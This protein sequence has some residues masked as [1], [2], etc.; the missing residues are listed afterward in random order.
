MKKDIKI[1]LSLGAIVIIIIF[2]IFLVKGNGS[3]NEKTAKCIGENSDLYTKLGCPACE[4]QEKMFNE[5]YHYL[6]KID[7]HFEIQK[8]IDAQITGTPTWVINEEKYPGV[9]T[10][11]KLKELT[12]C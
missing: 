11:E 2:G 5:N 4:A 7:C 10:I 8:C 1:Y 6:K 9:Q 12:G 3:A